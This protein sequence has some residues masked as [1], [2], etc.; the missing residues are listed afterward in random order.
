MTAAISRIPLLFLISDTG[1]GHRSAAKAVSQALER[2]H[3]GVFAPVIYD[4]LR[5]PGAP[6]RL[7]WLTALYGPA[8]RI[9]P[10]FWGV[11]WQTSNSRPGF[12]LYERT[13]FGPTNRTVA[14]AVAAHRPAMVISFHA[15]TIRP[16][17]R[18]RAKAGQPT[19]TPVVTVI[20]DLIT[21]HFAWRCG[22][23]D[24]VVVPTG[25]VLA[26]CLDE[27]AAERL[28]DLGLPV[29]AD[30]SAGPLPP[31][32]RA[33][34]RQALGVISRR[35]LVVIAGGAEGSGDLARR[36]AAILRRLPDVDVIALCG[37]NGQAR[38]R[39]ARLAASY[40]GRLLAQGFV[41]NMADWLRCADVVVTKAGPGMIAEATCCGAPMILTSHVPGQEQGNADFVVKA[42]AGR[43]APTIRKLVSDLDGLRQ[44]P[45]A[46]EEMRIASASLGRP[47]AAA[48]IAAMIAGLATASAATRSVAAGS[49]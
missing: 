6:P 23:V 13:L 36:A 14:A 34:L 28:V 41:D 20:T 21:P 40:G 12:W 24:Q 27:V 32:Q 9:T 25:A 37:R 35:F 31:E 22:A 1:G 11:L 3:P 15:M 48:D 18:A 4:P 16:A 46:L 26:R 2:L 39:L 19:G 47:G 10:W 17:I 5:D 7:R 33:E 43:Y 30:F 45:A 42:G 44:D 38:R 49:L 8:I 29:G